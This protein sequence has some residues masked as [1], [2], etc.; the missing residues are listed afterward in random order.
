[1]IGVG[2]EVEAGV[3]GHGDGVGA[4]FGR[5]SAEAGAVCVD[6]VELAFD[7]AVFERG[8]VDPV[9]R[10]VDADDGLAHPERASL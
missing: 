1:M 10:F 4:G 8:E 5:E 2:V 9:L 3:G 6:A 7:G